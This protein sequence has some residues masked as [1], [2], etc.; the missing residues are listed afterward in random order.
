MSF[1]QRLVAPF[2]IALNAGMPLLA[3]GATLKVDTTN[4][5]VSA[6]ACDLRTAISAVNKGQNQGGCLNSNN[7]QPYGNNDTITMV[8]GTYLMNFGQLKLE[9]S[10]HIQGEGLG[11]TLDMLSKSRA[12]HTLGPAKTT[13]IIDNVNILNGWTSPAIVFHSK[14]SAK[15][16]W[17]DLLSSPQSVRRKTLPGWTNTRRF[18]QSSPIREN[19][20][21]YQVVIKLRKP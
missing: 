15:L 18:K 6:N 5:A 20:V 13:V 4:D 8:A 10:V 3:Q 16:P 1:R 9:K 2:C 14:R 11:S 19:S 17:T 21:R 7:Q 12:F